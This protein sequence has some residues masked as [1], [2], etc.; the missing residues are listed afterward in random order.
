[1]KSFLANR[2]V[3]T[4]GMSGRRAHG[5]GGKTKMTKLAELVAASPSASAA[6]I[7]VDISNHSVLVGRSNLHH[8]VDDLNEWIAMPLAERTS[9]VEYNRSLAAAQRSIENEMNREITAAGL[10]RFSTCIEDFQRVMSTE[11]KYMNRIMEAALATPKLIPLCGMN[12]AHYLPRPNVLA[13]LLED[14]HIT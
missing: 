5:S 2:F 4:E 3:F 11:A 14:F 13:F 7:R 1:M 8:S 12:A 10:S 6:G 9:Y